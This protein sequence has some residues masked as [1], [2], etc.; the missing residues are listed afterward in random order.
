MKKGRGISITL[1]PEEFRA[2]KKQAESVAIKPGPYC[3]RIIIEHL[4]S[5]RK[6]TISETV[7]AVENQEVK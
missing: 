7:E 5:G 4:Q 6:I 2:V 1:S 3:K